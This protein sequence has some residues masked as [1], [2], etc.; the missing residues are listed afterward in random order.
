MRNFYSIAERFLAACR[1]TEAQAARKQSQTGQWRH[2]SQLTQVFQFNLT[3]NVSASGILP[4]PEK[5]RRA[6]KTV[7]LEGGRLVM[8]VL[9]DGGSDMFYEKESWE[10]MCATVTEEGW[11]G[12]R[13]G[14]RKN[15]FFRE[16]S[17]LGL[18]SRTDTSQE[19]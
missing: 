9:L 1:I 17:H 18:H 15:T 14:H 4:G 13:T 3:A 8:I 5:A 7:M 16:N 11:R 12:A 19:E 6:T 2:S 10:R